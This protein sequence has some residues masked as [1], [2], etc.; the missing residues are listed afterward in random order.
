M[1]DDCVMLVLICVKKPETK[2]VTSRGKV[3]DDLVVQNK[4]IDAAVTHTVLYFTAC[5]Q[6]SQSERSSTRLRAMEIAP[7]QSVPSGAGKPAQ[8]DGLP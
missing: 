4:L 3:T 5:N 7:G 1:I 6:G 8:D 2:A